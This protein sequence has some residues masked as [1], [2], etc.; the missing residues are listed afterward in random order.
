M[1]S[2][3][4]RAALDST[5]AVA[6]NPLS[7]FG[8]N[9]YHQGQ[10]DLS[11]LLRILRY[12]LQ[13]PVVMTL[14]IAS[15][16][17]SAGAAAAVPQLLGMF[18]DRGVGQGDFNFVLLMAGA[19]VAA[20]LVR[21][22]GE[23]SRSYLGER[24]SQL[25]ARDFRNE[26]FAHYQNLSF[27]YHDRARTGQLMSRATS[28][29]ESVMRFTGMGATM[30]LQVIVL[31]TL[32]IVLMVRIDLA[33]TLL[34]MATVPAIGGLAIVTGST[35][36]PLFRTLQEET[37]ELNTVLQENLTGHRVVR[38]FA[39][40][41]EQTE[42]FDGHN[43][44][45]QTA[46]IRIMRMFAIRGPLMTAV[47]GLGTV[48]VLWV[49][50]N[51]VIAGDLSLGV[52][53]A[54]NAYLLT[55]VMPV[56]MLGFMVN[57]SARAIASGERIFEILDAQ[58]PVQEKTN[59]ISVGRLQGQVSF[60][61]VTFLYDREPVLRDVSFNA[62]TGQVFGILG[63]TGSGKTSLINLIPRFYDVQRGA[64]RIDGHDLRD[65][66]LESLRRQIGIVLQD[67]YLFSAS[68]REN[69][70]YGRAGASLDEIVEAAKAAKAHEFIIDT[71][72]GYDTVIGERGV[73]LSGGQRQRIAITR[74]LLM[75]PRILILDDAT[76]SVDVQ[77]E[78][79]IQQAL[80]RLMEGRTTFIIAQRLSSVR[81]ADQI[82]VLEQGSIIAQGHH[83]QL[84]S[85]SRLYRAMLGQQL[86]LAA[87][88]RQEHAGPLRARVAT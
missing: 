85:E 19:I 4:S 18:V 76:S 48:A 47:A 38:A 70:A 60:D 78:I 53:V 25:V 22:G 50:G 13:H 52:L 5:A 81:Q 44:A 7:V 42:K 71:P 8:E 45:L 2:Y 62:Q 41:S 73:T 37:A 66:Q 79:E 83:D 72:K 17:L 57:M 64:I 74:A 23:F 88:T 59:A 68:I 16:V 51:R 29:V 24:I 30:M 9:R 77:T 36:R 65:L 58:S 1:A 46:S 39:R 49:G 54:F 10:L 28:D 33:L 27:G 55:L 15:L 14:S 11:T 32:T 43:R 35:L 20:S 63:M 84:L 61:N 75:D 87:E 12:V 34:A 6:P 3:A 31:V 56:R 86:Q 69:I 82:I 67:T 26:L 21:A 40:E 80:E